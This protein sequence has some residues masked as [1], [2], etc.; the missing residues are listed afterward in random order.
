MHIILTD[1]NGTECLIP[2]DILK[3]CFV[4]AQEIDCTAIINFGDVNMHVKESPTRIYQLLY[5]T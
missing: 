4:I 2:I 5:E 1:L 3:E